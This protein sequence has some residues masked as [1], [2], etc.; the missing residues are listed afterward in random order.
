MGLLTLMGKRGFGPNQL[1]GDDVTFEGGVG[2]W[3]SAHTLAQSAEQAHGGSN[4]GKVTIVTGEQNLATCAVTVSTGGVYLVEAWVYLVSGFT[5]DVACNTTGFGSSTVISSFVASGEGVWIRTW[6]RLRID[7]GD[8]SGTIR[9]RATSTP[10]ATE[11]GYIDD[12]KVRK[13]G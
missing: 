8:K 1:T 9:V 5:R 4:S 12:V 13:V 11:V 6:Q 7:S 3:V 2:N 10:I